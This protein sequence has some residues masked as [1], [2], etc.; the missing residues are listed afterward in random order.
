MQIVVST[1]R[2]DLGTRA[3]G[4]ARAARRL[5]SPALQ[6]VA[7][8]HAEFLLDLAEDRD[9]LARVV[10]ITYT[11]S[12]SLPVGTST[13]RARTGGRSRSGSQGAGT[14]G[15]GLEAGRRAARTAQ[16]LTALGVRA[17]VLDGSAVT[18]LVAGSVDPYGPGEVGWPRTPPEAA[19]TGSSPW[20]RT[21]VGEAG[22]V[23]PDL[24]GLDPVEADAVEGWP[25][26]LHGLR[27]WAR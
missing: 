16:A 22:L 17:A 9:P 7:V 5:T 27:G 12:T 8:G 20:A 25:A 21:G 18:A 4:V 3:L 23:E 13:G 10:T 24:V 11:A 2:V 26:E 15:A 14:G 1:R 6:Q 19:V